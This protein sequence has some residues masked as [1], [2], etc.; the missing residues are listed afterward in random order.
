[1]KQSC[2]TTTRRIKSEEGETLMFAARGIVVAFS[3]FVLV[4][5]ALSVAVYC[6]W[7]NLWFYSSRHPARRRADFLFALRVFPLFAAAAFTLALIVPSF[8]LLEPRAIVEPLGEVPLALGLC[9]LSVAVF[10][11]VN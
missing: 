1:M 9:G 2:A 10:G 11:L 3:V 5:S 4:Y 6:A 8:V 7:P